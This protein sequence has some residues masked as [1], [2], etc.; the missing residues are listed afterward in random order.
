MG[1]KQKLRLVEIESLNREPT[2]KDNFILREADISEYQKLEDI[3]YFIWYRL[4]HFV[5]PMLQSLAYSLMPF[6]YLPNF[7]YILFTW[8]FYLDGLTLHSLSLF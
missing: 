4:P 5:F 6:P 8:Y 3:V 1:T 2:N 7:L